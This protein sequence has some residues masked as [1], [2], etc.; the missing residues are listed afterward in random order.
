MMHD[1]HVPHTMERVK[2]ADTVLENARQR[3]EEHRNS[4]SLDNYQM[5]RE[6]LT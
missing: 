4:M 1:L 3:L 6:W 5:A 2:E